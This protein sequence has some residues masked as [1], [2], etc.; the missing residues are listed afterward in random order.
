LETD[1]WFADIE[2]KHGVESKR[3]IVIGRL[4][5]PDSREAAFVGARDHSLHQ[6]APHACILHVSFDRD[7][8]DPGNRRPFI[9]TVASDEPAFPLRNNAEKSWIREHPG[10]DPDGNLWSRKISRESMLGGKTTERF[11][12]NFAAQF[13]VL[14]SGPANDG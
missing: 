8:S 1:K 3:A 14:R 5:Q 7:G 11:E 6:L 4:D 2:T 10:E 12:A 13:R 9:Q